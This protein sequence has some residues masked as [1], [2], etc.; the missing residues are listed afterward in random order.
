MTFHATGCSFNEFI[1]ASGICIPND[2]VC[3]NFDD[4]RDGSD[5]EDCFHNACKLKEMAHALS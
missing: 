1:C 4:C 3:D 2:W 5:E